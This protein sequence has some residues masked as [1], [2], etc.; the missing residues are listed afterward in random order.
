MPIGRTAAIGACLLRESQ[1]RY[2]QI[3]ERVVTMR[4]VAAARDQAE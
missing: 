1:L 3:E 4:S 2:E